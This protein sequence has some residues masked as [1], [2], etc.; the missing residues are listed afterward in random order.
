MAHIIYLILLLFHNPSFEILV[1]TQN[2]LNVP[3]LISK[4]DRNHIHQ[5]EVQQ[6]INFNFFFFGVGGGVG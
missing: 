5:S 3:S 4:I 2:T 1:D 6:Q